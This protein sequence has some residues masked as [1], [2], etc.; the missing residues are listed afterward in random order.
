MDRFPT[1]ELVA[2]ELD[3][4]GLEVHNTLTADYVPQRNPL[5]AYAIS[6]GLTGTTRATFFAPEHAAKH[7]SGVAGRDRHAVILRHA[8]GAVTLYAAA[9]RSAASSLRRLMVSI[10]LRSMT[11]WTGSRSQ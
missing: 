4:N 1:Y 8:A 10:I 2:V 3:S 9:E 6:Y 5:R 7:E 11:K